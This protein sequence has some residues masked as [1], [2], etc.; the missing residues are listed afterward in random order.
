MPKATLPASSGGAAPDLVCNSDRRNHPNG[1]IAAT[2]TGRESNG[3]GN[4]LR[5]RCLRDE[6]R[7]N[8]VGPRADGYDYNSKDRGGSV[9]PADSRR[10]RLQSFD[11]LRGLTVVSIILVN[12]TAALSYLSGPVFPVM[13]QARWVVD[14][15]A[16]E[17]VSWPLADR[18]TP[19]VPR[20]ARPLP[21]RPSTLHRRSNAS[22]H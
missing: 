19:S 9:C 15:G 21:F 20:T 17:D 8:H 14:T 12:A 18:I 2:T 13:L 10:R 1:T 11:L 16:E 4:G 6:A 5:V 22:R 7:A 3:S